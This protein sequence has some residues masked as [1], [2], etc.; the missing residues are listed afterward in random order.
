MPRSKF[1]KV[2]CRKCR[3]EQ[4]IFNKVST[5]VKCLKCQNELATPTGGDAEIKGKVTKSLM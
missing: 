4:V 2:T 5:V 1:V 3:N